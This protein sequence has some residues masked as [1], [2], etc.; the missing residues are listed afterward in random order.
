MTREGDVVRGQARIS[1]GARAYSRVW[2]EP[3]DARANERA[4]QAILEADLVVL[5]PGSLFTSIVPNLLVDGIREALRDTR[6]VRVFVCPKIDSLGETSG[7]SVAEH[8]EALVACGLEGAIDV[9]L[10]HRAEGPEFVY[11]YEKRAWE[12][13]V[14]RAA[15]A[16][17]AATGEGAVSSAAISAAKEAPFGPIRATDEDLARIRELAGDVLVRDFTGDQSPAVHDIGR[18]AAALAEVVG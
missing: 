10:V 14:E 15:A 5:G 3:G 16:E 8:V 11:P 9:V 7:M 17:R 12:R 18:L 2:L 1:Y 4:V 13:V 6:A